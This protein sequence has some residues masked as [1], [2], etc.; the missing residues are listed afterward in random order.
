M[1]VLA[2][3]V[4]AAHS[5]GTDAGS[6]TVA[7]VR[8]VDGRPLERIEEMRARL[9][10]TT[11]LVG[12]TPTLDVY[13]QRPV[14]ADPDPATDEDWE[15]FYAFPQVTTS[16]VDK[17]VSL[18]LPLSQDADRSEERRVGK[19]CVSTCRSRRAPYH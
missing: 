10:V 7:T 9:K 16:A 4:V 18:P 17:V 15:D 8:E 1:G 13:L 6:A 19:E 2:E 11:P 5:T 14:A 12:D 3:T